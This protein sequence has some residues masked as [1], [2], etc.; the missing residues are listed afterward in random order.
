MNV[1][2]T[3]EYDGTCFHGWQ[4]Q[5]NADTVQDAV[6]T[7]LRTV[8]GEPV[9]V[10]GCSR[11]DAGVHALGQVAHFHTGAGIPG[12]RY[13]FALNRLLPP[14]VAVTASTEVPEN[15]HARYDARSK[16]YRYQFYRAPFRSALMRNRAYHVSDSLDLS[17]MA[18]AA[19]LFLGAHDFSACRAEGGKKGDPVRTITRSR[20]VQDGSLLIYEVI[21]NGFLYNMVRIMAGTLLSVGRGRMSPRDVAAGLASGDRRR[22]GI[23]L[24]PWGLCLVEIGYGLP[25]N[26]KKC[27]GE[28]YSGS[29]RPV[30]EENGRSDRII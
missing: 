30:S 14:A 20:I 2:L 6:E 13:V 16:F 23:T 3:L 26:E 19:A 11:T 5:P 9:R 17:A 4:S 15:F 29:I 25:I 22:M 1:R 8:T 24:P 7:A 12:D 28:G 18:E 21:G 27:H 10:V